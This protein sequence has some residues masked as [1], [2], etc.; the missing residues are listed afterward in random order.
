LKD[1]WSFDLVANTWEKLECNEASIN[2]RSGHSA[3]VYEHHMI[4]FAGIHEIT[5][6]QEDM[7][8]YSFKTKKWTHMFKDMAERG[9]DLDGTTNASPTKLSTNYKGSNS[10]NRIGGESPLKIGKQMTMKSP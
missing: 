2:E 1:F 6:E 9:S 10:P 3:C 5:K 8:A 7:A 4:I